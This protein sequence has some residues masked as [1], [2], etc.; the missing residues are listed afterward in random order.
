VSL[1]VAQGSLEALAAR[2]A[3][4]HPREDGDWTIALLNVEEARAGTPG[5]RP[6]LQATGLLAVVV[7]LVLLI[8]CANVANILMARAMARRGEMGVRMALGA[9]R[10][11]LVRQVLTEALFLSLMGGLAGLLLA[12]CCMKMIPLLG[13]EDGYPGLRVSLDL[14]VGAFATGVTV[15]TGMAFGLIP[16]LRAT[17]EGVARLGRGGPRGGRSRPV[18]LRQSLLA[19]QVAFSLVLLIGAGL[20]LR[21]L[22]NLRTLPL[23]FQIENLQVAELDLTAAKGREGE[24]YTEEEGRQ[25]YH[26]LAAETRSLPGVQ[27]A[28]LARFTPF[29]S[30]RMANDVVLDG[31]AWEGEENRFNV[32][33]NVV[34]P[35][36]FQAMDIPLLQGRGFTED[37][38]VG[39]PGVVVVNQSMAD[40]LWPGRR[41]VG[42]RLRL[43][44]G[45][46]AGPALEVVGVVGDGRY[47]RSWRGES[48]PF[49][50]LT[51]AQ[52]HAEQ[53]SLVVRGRAQGVP[54]A[55]AVRRTVA[56]MAPGMPAP[57]VSSVKILMDRALG[58]ERTNAKVLGLF[59][60]L[61][62]L[63]SAIGVYGVVSYSVTR[64]NHE[65]GV[66][67]ALGARPLDVRRI[68]VKGCVLPVLAGT[69]MGWGTAAGLGRF[70]GSFLFD[71][72][73]TDP[74]TFGGTAAVLMAAGVA[75][76]LIPS[77]RA[78]RVDPMEALQNE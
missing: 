73:A 36:Y 64:R 63:I 69:L 78:T 70:V 57:E 55:E 4:A 29:G 72:K 52:H 53:V 1:G 19:V 37:D 2:Q 47:Y 14:R 67:V 54:P 11:R 9:G 13:L 31:D 76:A 59:G 60:V 22:W 33:M 46:G 50:F 24:G 43:L 17:G 35:G 21:T 58:L 75:A 27:A 32:D 42:Q 66:R 7:G 45:E 61:A 65:I 38:R 3:E 23:G 16:A 26:A 5:R 25:I 15:V 30:R 56:E 51:L 18:S 62:L 8:A 41:A 10:R 77:R 39:G 49:L 71:V 74:L 34:G 6:L 20:A 44:S 48:R 68:F 12:F 40:R 28:G